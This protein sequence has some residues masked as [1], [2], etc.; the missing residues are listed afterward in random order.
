[1]S[2]LREMAKLTAVVPVDRSTRATPTC[3]QSRFRWK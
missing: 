1:V 3:H 2:G